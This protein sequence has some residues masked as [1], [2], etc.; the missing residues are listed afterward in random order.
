MTALSTTV[1]YHKNEQLTF[2]VHNVTALRRNRL[3]RPT[4]FIRYLA[5]RGKL[6]H[7]AVLVAQNHLED[8]HFPSSVGAFL[9]AYRVGAFHLKHSENHVDL[10]R[11]LKPAARELGERGQG[12][13]V[14]VEG[15]EARDGGRVGVVPEGLRFERLRLDEQGI[16]PGDAFGVH[17][18]WGVGRRVEEEGGRCET[19]AR[20]RS[21]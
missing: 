16:G 19:V 14:E 7:R 9:D 20:V 3:S 12:V 17:S 13:H 6:N 21:L 8:R 1:Y 15:W 4:P 2:D 11:A 10:L 5:P 18:G